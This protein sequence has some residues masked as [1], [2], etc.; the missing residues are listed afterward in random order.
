MG[1][2]DDKTDEFSKQRSQRHER[3]KSFCC[4]TFNGQKKEEK[5]VYTVH[6]YDII[7]SGVV[8]VMYIHAVRD[9]RC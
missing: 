1:P 7:F 5:K 9:A 6:V 4:C 3:R 8:V 2:A